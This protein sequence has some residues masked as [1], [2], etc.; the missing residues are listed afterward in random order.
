[1]TTKSGL[2]GR[3]PQASEDLEDLS[4]LTSVGGGADSAVEIQQV[5]MHLVDESDFLCLRER[6][7]PGISELAQS[8]N[9]KGQTTP[10]FLRAKD[11]GRY[12]L[13]SGYRRSEALRLIG[14]PTILARIYRM[15]LEKAYELAVSE[16]A[17][18]DALTDWERARAC[19]SLADRDVP[20][21]AIA[22]MFA[23]TDVRQVANYL[24][25]ARE[26]PPPLVQALQDR[27]LQATHALALLPLTEEPFQ[28]EHLKAVLD[29]AVSR[30]L[31]VRAIKQLVARE[32]DRLVNA[33]P[34]QQPDQ[35]S[36][37]VAVR[38]MKG[39]GFRVAASFRNEATVEELEAAADDLRALLRRIKKLRKERVDAAERED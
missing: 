24:R 8:I 1:M 22:K 4:F 2:G 18:R 20:R 37:L 17:E 25:L 11:D 23:W 12:D 19:R 35:P 32:S 30:Q 16:N 34:P 6:P 15:P 9:E 39:G 33:K 3:R 10:A 27:S 14:A 13:V 29:E 7:F 31:S 28:P 36:R 38:E 5:P 26:A 21:E